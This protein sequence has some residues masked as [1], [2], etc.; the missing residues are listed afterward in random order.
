[1]RELMRDVV[2][3]RFGSV[4]DRDDTRQSGFPVTVAK[5]KAKV[6]NSNSIHDCAHLK[7]Q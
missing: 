7:T 4:C 2:A 3:D 6:G 1:M 5:A